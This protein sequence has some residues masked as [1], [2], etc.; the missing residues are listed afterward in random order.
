MVNGGWRRWFA[1]PKRKGAPLSGKD[2]PSMPGPW[3][4]GGGIWPIA[5]VGLRLVGAAIKGYRH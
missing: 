1:S 2:A 3:S 4:E 5:E